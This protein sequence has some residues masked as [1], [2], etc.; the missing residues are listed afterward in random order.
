MERNEENS[1]LRCSNHWLQPL[2]IPNQ[3][4]KRNDKKETSRLKCR[5]PKEFFR[6]ARI[7]TIGN[8]TLIGENRNNGKENTTRDPRAYGEKFENA[9]RDGTKKMRAAA[10]RKEKKPGAPGDKHEDKRNKGHERGTN[11]AEAG[12]KEVQRNDEGKRK[13]I[14]DNALRE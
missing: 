6:N 12:G 8:I 1:S 5:K 9:E 2:I 4:K 14:D 7:P 3:F 11:E 10:G 13:E